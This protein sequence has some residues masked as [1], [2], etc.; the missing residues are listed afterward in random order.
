MEASDIFMFLLWN[1]IMCVQM[2]SSMLPIS[3]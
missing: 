3:I 2:K 1:A